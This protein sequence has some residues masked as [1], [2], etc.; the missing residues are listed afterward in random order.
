MMYLLTEGELKQ[1]NDD[2]AAYCRLQGQ[3]MK[4]P[5]EEYERIFKQVNASTCGETK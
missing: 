3:L 1:L 2:R 4:L 5:K